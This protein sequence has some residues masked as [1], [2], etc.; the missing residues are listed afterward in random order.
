MEEFVDRLVSYVLPRIRDFRG[1]PGKLDGNGNYAIGLKDHTIFP[2]VPPAEAGRI[3]GLQIQ[4][5]MTG[6]DDEKSKVLLREIGMPFQRK[7][8]SKTVD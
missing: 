6:G 2:E 7:N 1:L 5:T 4:F 3:F 8:P